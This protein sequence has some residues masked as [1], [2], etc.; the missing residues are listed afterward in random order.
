MSRRL[1]VASCLICG[2]AA[3]LSGCGGNSR[4]ASTSRASSMSSIATAETT[5]RTGIR[6]RPLVS[7]ELAG[8]TLTGEAVYGATREWLSSRTI[9]SRQ[10]RWLRRRRC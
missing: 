3:V 10:I 6:R 4:K 8:F 2:A 5:T 7:N 9:T 1:P